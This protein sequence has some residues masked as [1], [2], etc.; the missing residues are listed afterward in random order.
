MGSSHA[1][2]VQ[3]ARNSSLTCFSPIS[4][5]FNH[6]KIPD[7]SAQ[8][9]G[10]PAVPCGGG[11]APAMCYNGPTLMRDFVDTL[12]LRFAA[13]VAALAGV[14]CLMH[15][16]D[17][18][19]SAGRIGVTFAVGL[20]GGLVVRRLLQA[21]FPGDSDAA[22]A[23]PPVGPAPLDARPSTVTGRNIN[24]SAP[25]GEPIADPLRA[26]SDASAAEPADAAALANQR[27]LHHAHPPAKTTLP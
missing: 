16:V 3:P 14:V 11:G 26:G 20:V 10:G 25:G 24:V 23:A 27:A 17:L 21:A 18:W 8:R 9:N 5:V 7:F 2:A 15:G 6:Y 12:P 1:R 13:A 4:E 19:V 22:Q